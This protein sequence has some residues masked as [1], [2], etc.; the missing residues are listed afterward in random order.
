MATKK[1]T[2][3]SKRKRASPRR[4]TNRRKVRGGQ[5]D[6]QQ[7]QQQ[8]EGGQVDYQ[9]QQQETEGGQVDYQQQQQETEGGKGGKKNIGYCVSCKKKCVMK[10][11]KNKKTKNNRNMIVGNC[12]KCNTKMAKFVK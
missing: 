4:K 12:V 1:R 5:V 2:E 6:Y 10:N 3:L 9:Q 7:Q 11:C 8:T